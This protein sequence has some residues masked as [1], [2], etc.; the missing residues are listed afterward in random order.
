MRVGSYKR[1]LAARN[2]SGFTLVEILVVV[3]IIAIIVSIAFPV[4]VKAKQRAQIAECL[5]NMRQVGTALR[6]YVDEYNGRFPPAAAMGIPW[7]TEEN[8]I[9]ELLSPYVRNG[10][11]QQKLGGNG[12]MYPVRSVF[13]CPSD[14]GIP[15]KDDGYLGIRAGMTVWKQTG[16]SYIYYASNQEN[17]FLRNHPRVP[18]TGLSPEVRLTAESMEDTRI[19][20][21]ESAVRYPSRKAAM[22]DVWFWHLGDTVPPDN[23]VAFCNTLFVDG[24]AARV[25][26]AFHVQSRIETLNKHWHSY[27]ETGN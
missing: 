19:G 3:T 18:W 23:D 9:Q 15:R 6:V 26:G 8:T 12:Y 2:R 10:M 20:A 16:C 22:G 4:L 27:L 7:R 14:L 17:Y 5:S 21:P 11:I 25:Q 24:H 1:I 13:C